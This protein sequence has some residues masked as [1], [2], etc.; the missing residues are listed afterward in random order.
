MC[1]PF[2]ANTAVGSRMA[3][4]TIHRIKCSV[5]CETQ[6]VTFRRAQAW[7]AHREN[8]D[9]A[10]GRVVLASAVFQDDQAMVAGRIETLAAT[11]D[12]HRKGRY[13]NGL[14]NIALNFKECRRW[15]RR[16]GRIQDDK[17]R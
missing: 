16:K 4:S 3:C 12:N 7:V 9:S 1:I 13:R 8:P 15:R 10:A 17:S 11:S 5:F 14:D 6:L 2:K